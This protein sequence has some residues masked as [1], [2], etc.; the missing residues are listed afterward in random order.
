M[1]G[2]LE[3][4][5]AVACNCNCDSWSVGGTMVGTMVG[6]VCLG[7]MDWVLV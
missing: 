7:I 2:V 3:G 1:G 6:G 5:L 4:G